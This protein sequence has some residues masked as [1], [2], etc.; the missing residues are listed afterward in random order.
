MQTK[1]AWHVDVWC[2]WSLASIWSCDL[3][4][5]VGVVPRSMSS[6]RSQPVN[7]DTRSIRT[8]STI[9][10]DGNQPDE[11]DETSSLRSMSS[12]TSTNY[13]PPRPRPTV[14]P[15]YPIPDEA[16]GSEDGDE[17]E[18][19]SPSET[20]AAQDLPASAAAQALHQEADELMVS[21]Q[22]ASSSADSLPDVSLDPEGDHKQHGLGSNGSSSGNSGLSPVSEAES[23]GRATSTEGYDEEGLPLGQLQIPTALQDQLPALLTHKALNGN[24]DEDAQPSVPQVTSSQRLSNAAVQP[25]KSAISRMIPDP[26][27]LHT[28]RAMSPP[29]MPGAPLVPKIDAGPAV[30]PPAELEQTQLSSSAAAEQEQAASGDGTMF[31]GLDMM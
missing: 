9:L 15:L 21:S 26:E 11:A 20:E 1:S 24:D 29:S 28:P 14:R 27:S 12:T 19:S 10:D 7:A 4:W 3:T 8:M 18:T 30:D 22:H 31:A 25:G 17:G 23:S 2:V 16:A 13:G 5:S 6:S